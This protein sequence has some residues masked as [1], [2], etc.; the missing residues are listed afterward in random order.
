[1]EMLYLDLLQGPYTVLG[2]GF[3]YILVIVDDYTRMAWY[4]DLKE[5]DIRQAWEQ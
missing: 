3:R 2:T 1:M 4:I 5:K